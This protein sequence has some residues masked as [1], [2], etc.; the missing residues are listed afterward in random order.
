MSH[1]ENGNGVTAK[2]I[3][4]GSIRAEHFLKSTFSWMSAWPSSSSFSPS[5]VLQVW[6]IKNISWWNELIQKHV[7][8][9]PLNFHLLFLLFLRLEGCLSPPLRIKVFNF[10]WLSIHASS[11]HLLPCYGD[12]FFGSRS[13]ATSALCS[14]SYLAG[15]VH[16]LKNSR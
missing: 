7:P 5:A 12:L 16:R 13:W 15:K 10:F 14:S 6:I 9:N 3:L 4:E 8:E 2:I 11:C 1:S